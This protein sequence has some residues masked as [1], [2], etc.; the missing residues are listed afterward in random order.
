MPESTSKGRRSSTSEDTIEGTST[1]V[2]TLAPPDTPASIW[3]AVDRAEMELV[4]AE[5]AGQM[6]ETMA[7]EFVVD[8][9]TVR[10]LSIHGANE[11]A[12]EFSVRKM[13][14]ITLPHPPIYRRTLDG[15]GEE[16]YECDVLAV[17]PLNGNEAWGTGDARIWAPK[18]N[19]GV[20]FDKFARRKALSI[21]QRNAKLG[22]LPEE[23]KQRMVQS[24][25]AHQLRKVE[26]LRQIAQGEAAGKQQARTKQ[27]RA[28]APAQGAATVTVTA[29]QQRMLMARAKGAGLG[30]NDQGGETD[31]K[32]RAIWAWAGGDSHLDR[33][34]KSKVDAVLEAYG[35]VD[36]TLAAIYDA[37]NDGD[38]L[39]VKIVDHLLEPQ[40]PDAAQGQMA[41]NG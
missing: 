41:V 4:M 37:K 1:E 19:G 13:G 24:V 25:A 9:K 40:R 33:V 20:Y 23:L 2:T 29:S 15:A 5:I 10:G 28:K 38:E 21:A 16:V 32:L 27:T 22:I 6:I 14:R 17:D 26:T 3:E 35:D 8:G 39:A 34:H 36:G 18:K 12:R 31:P 7:Y 30:G 11:A